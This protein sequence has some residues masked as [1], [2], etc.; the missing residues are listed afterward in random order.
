[1]PLYCHDC[2][3]DVYAKDATKKHEHH[4]LE[5]YKDEPSIPEVQRVIAC[6]NIYDCLQSFNISLSSI[7]GRVDG[8]ILV[9]GPYR[10]VF[11]PTGLVPK[12]RMDAEAQAHY[13]M[14]KFYF[15]ESQIHMITKYVWDD[16]MEK[17]NAYLQD[18]EF[19]KDGDYLFVIDDD[20]LLMSIS[21]GSLKTI[22]AFCNRRTIQIGWRKQTSAQIGLDIKNPQQFAVPILQRGFRRAPDAIAMLRIIRYNPN[23]RYFPNHMTIVDDKSLDDQGR[24][25]L[26]TTEAMLWA[27]SLMHVEDLKDP[28]RLQKKRQYYIWR[29]MYETEGERDPDQSKEV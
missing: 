11:D 19:L 16:E 6:Y 12:E 14:A 4:M 20:E 28:T 17:R 2:E 1:M 9:Y 8:I 7:V 21:Q 15:D 22:L 25:Q 5:P 18:K 26:V 27:I 3:V 10:L 24:P 23:Y 13:D 29:N